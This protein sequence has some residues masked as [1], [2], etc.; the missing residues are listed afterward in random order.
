[1]DHQSRP[2]V[3]AKKRRR[4]RLIQLV[5]TH[6]RWALG[7]EDEGW[8]SRLAL[9]RLHAWSEADA[10]LRL[11]EQTGAT[12]DP[13]PTAL[14][15]YGLLVRDL[16]QDADAVWLRV[17][18]GRPVSGRTTQFLAW[19][20]ARLAA[21]GKTAL[22]LV[23]DNASWHLRREVRRWLRDHNRQAKQTGTGVRILS[24]F[25]PSKSPWLNPIEPRWV[26][27]KRAVVEPTRLRSAQE[28]AERV[29]ASF[30]GQHHEHLTMAEKVA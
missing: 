8:W 21:V 30:D 25:L 27:A 14:A 23:W 11:V 13:D 28:L 19:C 4:D 18:T 16:E 10:V 7:F 17:V 12:S 9:P 15:C 3:P 5:A 24:G 20:S 6:P 29:C 1:M 26:H 22:L 2:G